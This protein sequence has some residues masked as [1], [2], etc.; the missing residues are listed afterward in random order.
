MQKFNLYS[1]IVTS[2]LPKIKKYGHNG[3]EFSC[4]ET[5]YPTAQVFTKFCKICRDFTS[6]YLS[7]AQQLFMN[8]LTIPKIYFK[9]KQI[10]FLSLDQKTIIWPNILIHAQEIWSRL[11]FS[12]FSWHFLTQI[13]VASENF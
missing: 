4:L 11:I 7:R 8:P 6:S 13:L 1:E 10:Y 12:L 9:T 3:D 2:F 5:N